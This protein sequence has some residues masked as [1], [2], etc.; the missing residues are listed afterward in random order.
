[1]AVHA[2]NPRSNMK[3]IEITNDMD[4][5][6]RVYAD[7]EMLDMVLRNLLA[8]AIKF[9]PAGGHICIGATQEGEWVT[10]FVRDS[11]VGVD[12]QI[13]PSLFHEVQQTAAAGT[14][15]EKGTGLGLYLVGKFM[16]IHGGAIWY[17]SA[18]GQ[19][20]TFFFT[21][22]AHESATGANSTI[23]QVFEV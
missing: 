3:R 15:G 8:N 9:T 5:D 20:S 14:E 11:G 23:G 17:D 2:V 1:M 6:K 16:L 18:P 19:G 13:A 7:K 10:V 21:L 22:P 4:V 12:E